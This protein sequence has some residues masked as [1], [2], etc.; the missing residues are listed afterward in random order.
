MMRRSFLLV[1]ES[2]H[3]RTTLFDDLVRNQ[4]TDVDESGKMYTGQRVA[5]RQAGQVYYTRCANS[6]HGDHLGST[7]LT[8]NPAQATVSQARHYPYGAQRWT[9]GSTPTDIDFTGQRL[10]A[11]FGLL[12][13]NARYYD[14]TV[15]R[16]ISADSVVPDFAN[17]QHLNRYTYVYNNPLRYNDPTGHC[18]GCI[19]WI[20]NGVHATNAWVDQN[21]E[22][23]TTIEGAGLDVLPVV[24]DAKGLAEVFTGEDIVT[25]EKLGHWRWA[26]LVFMSEARHLRRVDDVAEAG[27][28]FLRQA[29][30]LFDFCSFRGDTLVATPDGLI[31]IHAIGVGTLVL[32]YNEETN[33]VGYYPVTASWRHLDPVIVHLTLDG[34]VIE[35]TPEHPFYTH[36][37]EWLAA[38]E[39]QVGEQLV[40]AD[41]STGTVEAISFVRQPNW[42]Y[43]LTVDVAHTYF[44]GQRRWLVH[45]Q[46]DP[47]VTR[48]LWTITKEGT[49]QTMRHGKFGTFHK[50]ATDGLWWSK[51][52]AGH[53]GS[54]WKVFRES[55]DGLEWLADA[56][57]YGDFIVGKH[58]GDTGKFIPWK[59]LNSVNK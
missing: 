25:G 49:E 24:G 14:P 43:N 19:R 39:L 16:F 11:S 12:D 17:S 41:G 47:S 7:A 27:G 22:T 6:G 20:A 33:Q 51:D 31:P 58:K 15:G 18:P 38:G 35:T 46:C 36:S 30:E 5:I 42:M 52:T 54:A 40:K 44:V 37:G 53:G 56:D 21:R 1:K 29:D 8:T 28:D 10:E 34:E 26:G 32:A 50:S 13:Y 2:I 23:L 55:S 57:K 9:S 48:G 4:T 3:S 59:E 45:N